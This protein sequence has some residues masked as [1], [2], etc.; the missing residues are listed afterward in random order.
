MLQ[1]PRIAVARR[2]GQPGPGD[3]E[4]DE[5]DPTS[6]ALAGEHA[7]RAV[8]EGPEERGELG[9]QA[10]PLL[11][12]AVGAQARVVVGQVGDVEHGLHEVIRRVGPIAEE[13]AEVDLR[14]PRVE[15]RAGI[16]HEVGVIVRGVGA[17][18]LEALGGPVGGHGEVEDLEPAIEPDLD[19]P[20]IQPFFKP[21]FVGLGDM[22]APAHID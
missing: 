20:G 8:A 7:H 19:G 3:D 14:E 4:V 13:V 12:L 10:V 1:D 9:L 2:V 21:V 11:E 22:N 5:R 6:P 15:H 16:E 18:T 17:E